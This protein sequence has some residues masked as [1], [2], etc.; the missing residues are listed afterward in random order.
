VE[1]AKRYEAEVT[2]AGLQFTK[3]AFIPVR[4]RGSVFDDGRI[5]RDV[6][7]LQDQTACQGAVRC[8]GIE[9]AVEAGNRLTDKSV[10]CL[11]VFC[12][13]Q[14]ASKYSS[15]ELAST[16]NTRSTI[17][18]TGACRRSRSASALRMGRREMLG[19]RQ[20]AAPLMARR[21]RIRGARTGLPPVPAGLE[22]QHPACGA[23][24]GRDAS[25]ASAM[26][27]RTRN[28]GTRT[29]RIGS[30]APRP[31]RCRGAAARA[32]DRPMRSCVHGKTGVSPV[33]TTRWPGPSASANSGAEVE[34]DF[35]EAAVPRNRRRPRPHQMQQS[36]G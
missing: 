29:R 23:R 12:P 9:P 26:P 35:A 19:E 27:V 17:T 13:G 21:P 15:S 25:A 4:N 14:M 11:Q 2:P 6:V 34:S 30:L 33:G 18:S 16:L 24:A 8:T 3:R 28:A 5:Q 1:L 10:K 22:C 32:A 7:L 20:V 31:A 36:P